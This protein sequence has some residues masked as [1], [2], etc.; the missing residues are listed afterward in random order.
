[1]SYCLAG[2]RIEAFALLRADCIV[3]DLHSQHEEWWKGVCELE[4]A[5]GGHES[6][7]RAE[8]LLVAIVR[9]VGI[10]GYLN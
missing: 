7:Q 9:Y 6:G 5:K 1:M 2:S 10:V 8:I 3:L 4:D